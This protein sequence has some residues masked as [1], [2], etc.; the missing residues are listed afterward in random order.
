M[1][2]FIVIGN[3]KMA[4]E[5]LKIMKAYPDALIP[6]VIAD[7]KDISLMFL[8]SYCKKE[9]LNFVQSHDVNSADILN[10]IE[11]IKPDVIFN[12]NSFQIIRK[13]LLKIPAEGIINFHN[14]PLPK[15]RGINVCTW[16]IV[17]GERNYGVSWHYMEESID[18]G[19]IVAQKI[20]NL[21]ESETA[22]SL[23]LKCINEGVIAFGE[24]F[25]LVLNGKPTRIRQDHELSSCYRKKDIPNNG[26][27]DYG[28]NFEKFDRFIRGLKFNQIPNNFVYPRSW[29]NSRIFHIQKISKSNK[30]FLETI[31]YGQIVNV[32]DTRIDV[33]IKDCVIS[34]VEIL[35]EE[36]KPI[37]ISHFI[38]KYHVFR[39][40]EERAALNLSEPS[41][42]M[43]ESFP[44]LLSIRRCQHPS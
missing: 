24:L 7:P 35:N 25:P 19:D 18:S 40:A 37:K 43:T 34:L 33:R 1:K 11:R 2:K 26:F 38:E 4:I 17:N 36:I 23:I 5:C 42:G 20:F 9:G 8:R 30:D 44:N 12:I 6:L 28:W 21:S 22:F 31:K 14:G 15:Y 13:V 27:V 10:K 16:A 39:S 3:G 32:S 41:A 29:L